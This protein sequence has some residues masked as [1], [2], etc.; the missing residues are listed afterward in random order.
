MWLRVTLDDDFFI[1]GIETVTDHSPHLICPEITDNFQRLVGLQIKPGW[2]RE[3]LK[4]VGGT[5]GCT[6]LVDLLTPIAVTAF[7][8]IF[9][10]KSD[11]LKNKNIERKPVLLNTCHAY[12]TE[13]AVVKRLWPEYYSGNEKEPD[14]GSNG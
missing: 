10:L 6:H 9:P 7:Q 4:V 5:N 14:N 8:T 2:R 1:H 13:G 11:E 3:V 12:A